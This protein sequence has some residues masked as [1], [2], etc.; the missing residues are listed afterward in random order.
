[1]AF[2]QSLAPN[3]SEDINIPLGQYIFMGAHLTQMTIYIIISYLLIGKKDRTLRNELSDSSI[4]NL[5]ILKRM[6]LVLFIFLGLFLAVLLWIIFVRINS[7]EVDYFLVLT[8][9]VLVHA[10]AYIA[11]RQPSFFSE[12]LAYNKEK[13][14]T[15]KLTK[16]QSEEIF[17]KIKATVSNQ[18][19]YLRSDYKISDLAKEIELPAHYI[20]QVINESGKVN[21]FE[22]INS[23]RINRAKELLANQSNAHLKIVAIA[24]DSGFNNKATFNRIFKKETG[25]TPSAYREKFI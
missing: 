17:N 6:T 25:Y 21:F 23:F 20:S 9:T 3:E 22:F 5:L 1:M 24:F 2:L 11:L 18:E 7:V 8:L 16:S 4:V 10:L 14:A 15:Y 12:P 13:Y 19:L